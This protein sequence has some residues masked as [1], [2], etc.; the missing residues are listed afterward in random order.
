[1]KKAYLGWWMIAMAIL[2]VAACGDL[3]D[4]G[5]LLDSGS[6][7]LPN[8]DDYCELMSTCDGDNL[9]YNT[10]GPCRSFCENL[11]LGNTG[12]ATGNSVGCRHFYAIQAGEEPEKYCSAA[13]PSGGDVCGGSCQAFCEVTMEVCQGD[14]AA[15][16]GLLACTTACS[17]F[18]S[19]PAYSANVPDAHTLACRFKHLNFATLDS[20]THCPHLE[21][22]SSV[23]NDD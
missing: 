8:C 14:E 5:V 17:D 21:A 12:D 22:V 3:K 1:M 19:E 15:Y 2:G 7:I 4:L 18:P 13:G 20:K 23:C 6:V 11:P 16:A 10:A 9:Q